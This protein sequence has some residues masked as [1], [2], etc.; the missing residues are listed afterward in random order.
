M[1][2]ELE[3]FVCPKCQT[4]INM[5]V[6]GER[7]EIPCPKCMFTIN[8]LPQ[9][10]YIRGLGAF[11]EGQE[12]VMK[13]S[14]KKRMRN[15]YLHELQVAADLYMQAYSALQQAFQGEL[16]ESQ[17]RLAIEMMA[18]ISQLFLQYNMISG[19]EANYWHLIMVEKT[20]RQEVEK[21]DKK[22]AKPIP[23]GS[24][25]ILRLRWQIRKKQLNKSLTMID[26]K[27][28]KLEHD[29]GFLEPPQVRRLM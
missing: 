13:V 29:I 27:I 7:D 21:I 26:Q 23:L 25:N 22:L 8:I 19:L 6:I 16:G 1:V 12:I 3:P 14:P 20:T 9:C 17:R 2:T 10:A 28:R 5:P 24:L 4:E 11:S 18:S 15:P